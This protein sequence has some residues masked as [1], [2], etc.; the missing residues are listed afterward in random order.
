MTSPDLTVVLPAYMEEKHILQSITR[1]IDCLDGHL[2]TFLIR[3]VVDGPGD[4]TADVVQEV[5]DP[6][7]SV[8][9]LENNFG[10][11]RAVREGLANCT[12]EFVSYIDAD[13]DLHPAGLVSGFRALLNSPAEVCAAIGS[14][15]HPDSDVFYPLSR[16]ILSKIYKALV[17][18]L[19]SLDLNDTQTGMK[20]FR[21]APLE[22]VLPRLERSGFEF[23]LELLTRLARSGH[24]FIEV[25]VTL[26][27]RFSST[28]NL[29]SGLKTLLDTVGLAIQLRRT[30]A[31]ID[32]NEYR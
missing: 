7:L 32:R 19:F 21:R 30:P 18:I 31:S 17:R 23:D 16:R 2:I 15:V 9:Q 26:D 24:Q 6:R 25:P 20:V 27:Y 3:V 11:G 22:D 13:L 10:K 14:K 8:I 1:L 29:R 12:T 28:V 4:R 5:N